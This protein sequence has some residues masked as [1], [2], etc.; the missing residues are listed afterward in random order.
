[1]LQKNGND[2]NNRYD[3][4]KKRVKKHM[5]RLLVLMLTT[6]LVTEPL[7]QSFSAFGLHEAY[8]DT[9]SG[10]DI[11]EDE[12]KADVDSDQISPIG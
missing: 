6:I 10:T 9:I 8:A 2:N 5:K 4:D 11:P 12:T 7:V 1:M 3:Y